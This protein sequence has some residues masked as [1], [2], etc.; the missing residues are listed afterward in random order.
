MADDW[1]DAQS[2]LAEQLPGAL[3]NL[4][5]VAVINNLPHDVAPFLAY[6]SEITLSPEDFLLEMLSLHKVVIN[7]EY[8]RRKVSWDMLKRLISRPEFPDRV[9]CVFMELPSWHQSTM[10]RFMNSAALDT[11][12]LIRIFQ[13]EQLNGWWDRGE[14]EFLCDLCQI[15]QSLPHDKKIRVVLAD[16]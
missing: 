3:Y 5:R 11:G 9:G 7:G 16:Y 2:L 15:N 4:P 13:D 8:H 10:D 6:I 1:D 12:L 14:F